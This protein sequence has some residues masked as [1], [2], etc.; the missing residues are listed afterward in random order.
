MEV[1]V[2]IM[3]SFEASQC[4]N[5]EVIRS[6]ER[7]FVAGCSIIAILGA[8]VEHKLDWYLGQSLEELEAVLVAIYS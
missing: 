1:E 2:S 8:I 5:G 3:G 7:L 6:Y 4:F